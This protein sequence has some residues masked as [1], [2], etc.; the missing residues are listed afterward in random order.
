V[1]KV[2][3]YTIASALIVTVSAFCVLYWGMPPLVEYFHV[4]LYAT[5]FDRLMVLGVCLFCVAVG[6]VAGLFLYPLLLRP[7]FSPSEYWAWLKPQRLVKVPGLSQLLE[8][9]SKL[10]YGKPQ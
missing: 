10:L 5:G 4:P 8:W 1:S 9:W 7:V 2:A 6:T 3:V